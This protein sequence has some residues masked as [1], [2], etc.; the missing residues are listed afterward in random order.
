MYNETALAESQAVIDE[1]ICFLMETRPQIKQ[2]TTVDTGVCIKADYLYGID[3]NGICSDG[4]NKS[5][6]FK[7]RKP[8]NTDFEIMG[9]KLSGE[10]AA[11]ANIGFW[12]RDN[13]YALYPRADIYVERVNGNDYSITSDDINAIE[14]ILSQSKNTSYFISGIQPKYIYKDDGSKMP[15]GDYYVFISLEK[16]KEM[17]DCIHVNQNPNFREL[18]S[19]I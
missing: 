7:C 5:I 9:K 19:L 6:Q 14:Y 12:Y 1:Q 4:K 11:K 15:T 13:K 8:G 16:L 3:A 2:V 17:L 18:E 10:A